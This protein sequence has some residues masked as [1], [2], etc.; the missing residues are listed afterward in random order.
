MGISSIRGLQRY[1]R[2]HS[3][4]SGKTINSVIIALGYQP[5]N[6]TLQDF[7][8]LSGI[9][10]DCSNNGAYNGFTGFSYYSDTVKFYMKHQ[11]NIVYHLEEEAA[12]LEKDAISY[13][14]NLDY[15]ANS[16]NPPTPSK[17]GKALWNKKLSKT[18]FFELYNA[19]AWYTLEE[20]SRIWHEYIITKP[21][22]KAKISA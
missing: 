2:R 22:V 18:G 5:N 17:V 8:E 1:I 13:V 6:A 3:D 4:F 21:T 15:I 19:L 20:V 10:I 16:E 11:K 9:F 14:L 12:K 7:K